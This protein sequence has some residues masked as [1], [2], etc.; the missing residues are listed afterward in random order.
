VGNG[1]EMMCNEASVFTFMVQFKKFSGG[2]KRNQENAVRIIG[3][4]A[5]FR[6]AQFLKVDRVAQSA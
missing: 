4:P 3:L 2:M 5:K 1:L 6:N